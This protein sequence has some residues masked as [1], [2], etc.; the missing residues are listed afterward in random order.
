MLHRQEKALLAFRDAFQQG[1]EGLVL[2]QQGQ[3]ECCRTIRFGEKGEGC[4]ER[5]LRPFRR[6]QRHGE[7]GEGIA[8]EHPA[9]AHRAIAQE[10]PLKRKEPEQA[11]LS[12]HDQHARI[13]ARGTGLQRRDQQVGAIEGVGFDRGFGEHTPFVTAMD[14]FFEGHE[15]G[16]RRAHRV[17]LRCA[18]AKASPAAR[19]P[20]IAA[21]AAPI[22]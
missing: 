1:R 10:G 17:N 8:V 4:R 18:S 19:L 21:V 6:D 14:E 13:I 12:L 22:A 11:I 3:H 9:E 5:F 7:A 16:E 15:A 20:S 2:G